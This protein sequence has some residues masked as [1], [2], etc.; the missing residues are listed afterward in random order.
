MADERLRPS[1]SAVE[2]R[3]G[4]LLIAGRSDADRAVEVST[5][6]AVLNG[7]VGTDKPQERISH[8]AVR[9]G[10]ISVNG[11]KSFRVDPPLAGLRDAY[12]A[13]EEMLD[14]VRLGPRERSIVARLWVSEG[15]PFAFQECPALYE[16]ARAWLAAGLEV[17]SKEI[18]IGGSGRL[19]YS[20]A[21]GRWGQPYRAG[22]SDLDLFTVSEQLFEKL[23]REFTQ[24]SRDFEVGAVVPKPG[25][26]ERFW[27]QNQRE[28]P[29]R[30]ERG[31]LNS[32]E[33]PN[34]RPYPNF[35]KTNDRLA[36]LR[37]RL[38]KTEVGPKPQGKLSLRCYRDWRS[39]ERQLNLNLKTAADRD[40]V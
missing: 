30:I 24:W 13:S 28:T 10:Q 31:F 8:D 15:I 4:A 36:G 38:H 21:P 34:R 5:A 7:A 1:M 9:E 16:E 32:W 17:D 40:S 3:P 23:R 35:S 29:K 2:S 33:V 18:S 6:A 25:R 11:P 22:D 14:S 39:F 12:P 37:V 26:E 20:L 19:G 27:R